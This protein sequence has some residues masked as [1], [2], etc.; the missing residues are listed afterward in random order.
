MAS[1][2]QRNKNYTNIA[3]SFMYRKSSSSRKDMNFYSSHKNNENTLDDPIFTGFT[4][5]IDTLHSPLFYT[6]DN[7]EYGNIESLRGGGGSSLASKIETR[8]KTQQ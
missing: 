7:N 6:G 5:D 1:T 4:F 3:E 8:L 2:N